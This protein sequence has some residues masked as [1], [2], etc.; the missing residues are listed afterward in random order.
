VKRGALRI[1]FR[2]GSADRSKTVLPQRLSRSLL[3]PRNASEHH[4]VTSPLTV[5]LS[6]EGDVAGTLPKIS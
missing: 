4:L 2:R 5:Q 3:S 6:H 1:L